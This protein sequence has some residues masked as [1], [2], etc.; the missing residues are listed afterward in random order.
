MQT[1]TVAKKKYILT[2]TEASAIREVIRLLS[3]ITDDDDLADTIQIEA[4]S[5]VEDTEE[6]LNTIL[7]LEGKDIEC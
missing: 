4:C 3:Q 7:N 2:Q 1:I 6:L 5:E